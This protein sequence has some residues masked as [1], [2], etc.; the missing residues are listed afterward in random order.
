MADTMRGRFVWH[1]LM[2][3]DPKAAASFYGKVVGWAP[4]AYDKNPNYTTLTYGGAPMG[5]VLKHDAPRQWLPYI[6]TPNVDATAREAVQL[7]GNVVK[8]AADIPDIGRFAIISDPQGAMFI[9]FTPLPMGTSG[10]SDKPG[11]GDFHWHELMTTDWQ[12]AWSFYQRLFGWHKTEAMEM[13]PGQTY[14][15]FAPEGRQ[16]VG[17]MFNFG[18]KAGASQWLSYAIVKDAKAAAKTIESAGGKVINGPMEVP[19]GDW[20]TAGIDPQGVTFAVHSRKST[21]PVSAA[22]GPKASTATTKTAAPTTKSAKG[23]A[24]RTSSAQTRSAKTRST[25]TKGAKARR[26]KTRGVKKTKRAVK[27]LSRKRR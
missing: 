25:K 22:A 10:P 9:A 5:G 6:A 16:T 21:M 13:A 8:P 24:A 2:T 15:M 3:P 1:E 4:Q 19:G 7:G 20:I 26:T 11:L 18:E 23:S 27:K 17:G 12:K 14:Q